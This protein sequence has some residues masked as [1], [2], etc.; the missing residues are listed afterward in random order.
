MHCRAVH[1]SRAMAPE[2]VRR[3]DEPVLVRRVQLRR[4][5]RTT[6][7]AGTADEREVV[8]VDDVER[9]AVEDPAQGRAVHDRAARLLR[10]RDGDRRD[11]GSRVDG[12]RRHRHPRGGIGIAVARQRAIRVVVAHDGD[13]M[14]RAHE[15][16]RERLHGHGVPAEAPRRIE[17]GDHA[18]AKGLTRRRERARRGARAPRRRGARR[19]WRARWRAT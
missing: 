9:A 17:R 18:E 13:V 5:G 10:E 7:A 4:V 8:K 19:A 14:P 11:A 12:R 1:G 16:A 6:S 2:H 15:R 3:A